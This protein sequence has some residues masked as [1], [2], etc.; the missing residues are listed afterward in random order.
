MRYSDRLLSKVTVFWATS[1]SMNSPPLV[2]SF[3]FKLLASRGEMAVIQLRAK[4]G[5]SSSSPCCP[6]RRKKVL[7]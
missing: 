6:G 3:F 5:Y 1:G 2:S 7:R 4:P